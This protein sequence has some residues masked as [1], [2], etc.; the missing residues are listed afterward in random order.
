MKSKIV[1]IIL[2]TMQTLLLS[3]QQYTIDFNI[4]LQQAITKKTV[5]KTVFTFSY[6]GINFIEVSTQQGVF[7]QMVVPGTYRSGEVGNPQLISS[8]KLI[9][10]PHNC[11]VKVKIIDYDVTEYFIDNYFAD[12]K[13][14]PYQPSYAKSENIADQK[15]IVNKK[16][17]SKNTYLTNNLATVKVL[18][19]MRDKH[20]AKL[21]VNPVEYNPAKNSIRFYNNIKVKLIYEYLDNT[22]KNSKTNNTFSPYFN[23]TFKNITDAIPDTK[24]TKHPDL[25]THPVKYLIVAPDNYISTLHDFI[26][27]KTQKGYQIVVGNINNIGSTAS[28][29]KTWIQNQYNNSTETNPAPSFLLLVGDVQQLPASQNGNSTHLVTD[30]YYASVDGDMFPD[31]YYGRLPAQDTAQ[32]RVMLTKTMYYDKYLFADDSYLNNVTLI[33]GADATWNPRVGQPTI[34]YGTN[35]YFNATNDYSNINAY[36]SSYSGCYDADKIAVGMINYTAHC[37]QTS[38]SNPSL[39]A[40]TVSGFTNAGKYPIAI[41]NCCTSGDFNVNECIGEAWVRNPNGGSVVYIGSVPLTYWWEDFYWSVGAHQPVYNEYPKKDSSG[42]GAYDAAFIND[43]NTVDA[44]VFIGNLAVTEAHNEGYNS[45]ISS[46]YYWEAYHCFG[47]PSLM[48]YFTK[49]KDNIVSHD[50]VFPFG[51]NAF[52]VKAL[53]GSLVALSN[54]NGLIGSALA[55]SDSIA[56]ITTDTLTSVDSVMIV[57]TKSQYKPYIKKIPVGNINGTYLIVENTKI[58]DTQGNNNGVLDFNDTANIELYIKNIGDTTAHNITATITTNDIYIKNFTDNLNIAVD[59][60]QKNEI[61]TLSEKFNFVVA[62]SVPDGHKITFNIKLTDSISGEE[63]KTYNY[64]T[65]KTIAAPVFEIF[66]EQK[67]DDFLT[68]GNGILDYGETVTLQLS[69][70]NTGHSQVSSTVNLTNI[71]QNNIISINTS[72]IYFDTLAVNDT[73]KVNFEINLPYSATGKLSDTLLLK[74]ESGKYSVQ[75]TFIVNTGQ[76]LSVQVGEGTI[77]ATNYPFNNYY[78]NNTTQIL[79]H[80]NDFSAGIKVLKS[81]GFN[82]KDFTPDAAYRDL[83]NFK[84]KVLETDIDELKSKVDF[85][86]A[87]TVYDSA[88]Y[89][90]PANSG[91]EIFTMTQPF[92]LSGDKN[93][94]FEIS[95]GTTDNYAHSADRTTV[96]ATQTPYNSIVWGADDNVYPAPANDLSDKRPNTKFEFD[97]VGIIN[98][99]VNADLPLKNGDKMQD[100]SVSIDSQTK[101]T[102]S[103]GRTQFYFTEFSGDYNINFSAYGYADTSIILHKTST[104][105]LV[106]ITLRRYPKLIFTVKNSMGMPLENAVVALVDSNFVTNADGTAETYSTDINKKAIFTINCEGYNSITD[107]ILVD[108]AEKSYTAVLTYNFADITVSA[109]N[110]QQSPM[111]NVEIYLGGITQQTDAN[112]T[113]IFKD[114]TQGEYLMGIYTQGYAYITDTVNITTN[115][116]LL[117]YTL[118]KLLNIYINLSDGVNSLP[119]ITVLLDTIEQTTNIYG[120]AEFNTIAEGKHQITVDTCDYYLFEDTVLFSETDT[121][122]NVKL[123]DKPEVTFFVSNGFVCLPDAK[124]TFDT[125]QTFTDTNGLAVFAN[126]TTGYHKYTVSAQNY[127]EITDSVNLSVDTVLNIVIHKIPDVIFNITAPAEINIED[128]PLVFDSDT[129]F[130]DKFGMLIINGVPKGEH[131]YSINYNGCQPVWNNIIVSN[132]NINIDIE[133]KSVPDIKFVVSSG[134]FAINN[135]AVTVDD[136]VIYTDMLGESL[137]VDFPEREYTY[138]ISKQGF[139]TAEGQFVLHDNDTTIYINLE[140]FRFNAG[141]TVTSNNSAIDSALITVNGISKYTDDSGYCLF[142]DILANSYHFSVK[143]DGY[144]TFY[145]T[146]SVYQN[147]NTYVD[148]VTESYSVL[149]VVS[150]ENGFVEGAN[151]AFGGKTKATNNNG[152]AMFTETP[153]GSY[154]YTVWESDNH[155]TKQ[156]DISINKDTTVNIYLPLIGITD[157][158]YIVKIYPNPVKNELFV[159]ANKTLINADYQILSS[160]G[161]V[162]LKG[163]ITN[164]PHKIELFDYSKGMY[165][166]KITGNDRVITNIFIIK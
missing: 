29:I 76:N 113:T 148:L 135:V 87:V 158:G 39:S 5:D 160:S 103:L 45:D 82:I 108:A 123:T 38:W 134:G 105:E 162:I 95:W 69:I 79:Y 86:S 88:V 64:K 36:L 152:S 145:D 107:T 15:F 19:N 80:N 142:E 116:T 24:S 159:V 132:E 96:Y 128:V 13:L 126:S 6:S 140:Q 32:L 125:L 156:G 21:T 124:I 120:T 54:S 41:A 4:P 149:F 73:A 83:N 9:N 146:I 133:L 91:W 12:N 85:N 43:Y 150:D 63:Q 74:V 161:K 14:I 52:K 153:A 165:F 138:K 118:K 40:S 97:S 144:Q 121:V 122:A 92:I 119:N 68:G 90:L 25:E 34:N 112:G 7:N 115:D 61:F 127:I 60:I 93:L 26:E 42:T 27:W 100:C 81:I 48:P 129:L 30:L 31:M 110:T 51:T 164:I 56:Q 98:I 49:G 3:A 157:A 77:T 67:I 44:L 137:F 163:K 18:G 131:T 147:I 84:I 46:Q 166:I 16:T 99:Q 2:L 47:D 55:A 57:V 94:L 35:Y 72:G 104:S 33:A 10:I 117:N 71:S 102:D 17:Y 78:K 53:P 111:Q 58:I 136:S 1:Y 75:D 143:K 130:A 8:N 151:I 28:D 37:S 70:A 20:I 50:T 139:A 11:K 23:G 101:L 89:H 114:I 65:D 62:D 22:K 109:K 59:S 106:N 155:K 66:P 154:G 141:F